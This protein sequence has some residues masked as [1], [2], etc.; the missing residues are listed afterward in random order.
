M[1]FAK[2]DLAISTAGVLLFGTI[3]VT[4]LLNWATDAAHA[5]YVML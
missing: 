1:S 4:P 2:D 3:L 5:L